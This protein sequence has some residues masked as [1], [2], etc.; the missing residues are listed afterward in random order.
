MTS[1]FRLEIDGSSRLVG[2]F[3]NVWACSRVFLVMRWMILEKVL[4]VAALWDQLCFAAKFLWWP[5]WMG[6]LVPYFDQGPVVIQ[7]RGQGALPGSILSHRVRMVGDALLGGTQ[8]LTLDPFETIDCLSTCIT[9]FYIEYV[10]FYHGTFTLCEG[11]YGAYM[12][13][14]DRVTITDSDGMCPCTRVYDVGCTWV[15]MIVP[16]HH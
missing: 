2:G 1:G 10:A 14:P 9:D 12:C 16:H 4:G 7:I 5:I 11:C 3:H 13:I 6:Y 15:S 8:P